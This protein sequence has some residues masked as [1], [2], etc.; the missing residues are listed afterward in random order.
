MIARAA[1]GGMRDAQSLLDQLVSFF[2]TNAGNEEISEAQALF[3]KRKGAC[4][5]MWRQTR[6][7]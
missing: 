1:D 7:G 3:L 6:T 5:F 2:G 4:F